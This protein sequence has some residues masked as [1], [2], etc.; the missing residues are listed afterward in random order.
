VTFKEL[1]IDC[2]WCL[3]GGHHRLQNRLRRKCEN[4]ESDIVFDINKDPTESAWLTVVSSWPDIG[5][6]KN[7]SLYGRARRST[8][9]IAK[10]MGLL[11]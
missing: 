5:V 3:P 11:K 8:P 10:R 9:S 1:G 6:D 7:V 4:R 2:G